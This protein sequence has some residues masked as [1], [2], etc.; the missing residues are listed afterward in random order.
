M[1]I[2]VLTYGF[3]KLLY[4]AIKHKHAV[5]FFENT[6]KSSIISSS[7]WPDSVSLPFDKKKTRENFLPISY[8]L[9]P[10]DIELKYGISSLDYDFNNLSK[11][12]QKK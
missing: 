6:L 12:L 4:F 5:S 3:G 7:T 11:I 8:R 2:V 1:Y 9:F 10:C